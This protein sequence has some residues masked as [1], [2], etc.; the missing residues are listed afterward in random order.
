MSLIPWKPFSDFDKFFENDDWLLPV[1]SK[2]DFSRPAMDIKE[3]EKEIIAEVEIPGFDPKNIEI[4]VDNGVLRISGKM[5]EKKEEKEKGYW[6]KEI[7]RGSFERIVRLP[8]E[9]KENAI[10]ATYEKGILKIV[11]P[12]AEAKPK[13]KVKIKVKEG[14]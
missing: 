8:E 12:K 6:K 10:E 14:K 1:F 7:R 2:T 13:T 9:V 3:T 11:M 5:D 4:S